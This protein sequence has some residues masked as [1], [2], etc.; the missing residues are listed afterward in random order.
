[1][2]ISMAAAECP[3]VGSDLRT[4]SHRFKEREGL[5]L[6]VGA[7]SQCGGT[8]TSWHFC[9]GM[10][11]CKTGAKYHATFLVYRPI[12]PRNHTSAELS[13]VPESIKSVSLGCRNKSKVKC[14]KEML[15]LSEQFT[16]Q[17]GDIV[18]ACLPAEREKQ[19][20]IISRKYDEDEEREGTLYQYFNNEVEVNCERNKIHII[21]AVNISPRP[22]LQLHLQAEVAAPKGQSPIATDPN[23]NYSL[24]FN[25][26]KEK[27]YFKVAP[28]SIAGL[29]ILVV[30]VATVAGIALKCRQTLATSPSTGNHTI[31]AC[32]PIAHVPQQAANTTTVNDYTLD[33]NVAYS[34][35]ITNASC[36]PQLQDEHIYEIV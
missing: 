11:E 36:T 33:D 9:Y 25:N 15:V 5:Y 12:N 16:I 20:Q 17:E 31:A 29:V 28:A 13:I 18:A 1:M 30:F 24:R 21:Q 23:N 6:N 2:N 22:Y 27:W 10:S 3:I 34:V 26:Q 35:P 8:V 32:N 19:L 14:G 7:P 4:L